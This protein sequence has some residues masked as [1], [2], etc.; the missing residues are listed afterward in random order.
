MVGV[1]VV[2]LAEKCKIHCF[3]AD[4]AT[5]PQKWPPP[6]RNVDDSCELTATTQQPEPSV[7]RMI[8]IG[9]VF[10]TAGRGW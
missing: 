5:L 4:R 6:S 10:W 8:D 9:A 7:S 1:E 2:G 3:V